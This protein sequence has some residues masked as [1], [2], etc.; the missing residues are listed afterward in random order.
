VSPKIENKFPPP[1]SLSSVPLPSPLPPN[2]N[3]KPLLSPAASSLLDLKL[4][5]KP[6][7]SSP[8][9]A[10]SSSPP[11]LNWKGVLVSSLDAS[12]APSKLNLNPVLSLSAGVSIGVS[13]TEQTKVYNSQV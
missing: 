1:F 2:A 13:N 8:V 11:K 9:S 7:L 6:A 5:L 12:L 4:K 10:A 3:L